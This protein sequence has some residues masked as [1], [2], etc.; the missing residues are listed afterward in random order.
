MTIKLSGLGGVSVI[1]SIQRGVV[2]IPNPQTQTT[3]TIT[4]VDPLKSFLV[5]SCS[6][7]ILDATGL[8]RGN[9]T[10]ATTLTFNSGA[11]SSGT[12]RIEWQVIEY[13]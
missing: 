4:A 5:M 11:S 7:G 13:N 12:A 3:V 6:T 9:I 10:N 1:K 8:S 2:S